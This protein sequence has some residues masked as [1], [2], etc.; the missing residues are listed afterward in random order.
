MADLCS[1]AHT[2]TTD[3][4]LLMQQEL[5]RIFY[6]TPTNFIELLKG[7]IQIIQEKRDIIEKQ[8]TKLRNGLS[9]L[10]EARV[11]VEKMSVESEV[12]RA[13]VSKKQKEA[14]ELMIYIAK[15]RKAADE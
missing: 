1:Y 6:V 2:T 5:K 3:N 15:E 8:S 11:Q 9:K 14:E 10:D 7:Y 12:K 13:E 4:A